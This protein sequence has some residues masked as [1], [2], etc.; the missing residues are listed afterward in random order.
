MIVI[1]QHY[2][3]ESKSL[4]AETKIERAGRTCYKTED[5][6]STNSANKFVRML[7]DKG[8]HAMIEFAD[9]T[10]VFITNR[11][12]THELVRHRLCSFAQESTRY[13]RYD[14]RMEIIRPMWCRDTVPLGEY[15]GGSH[16]YDH[17]RDA[18]QIPCGYDTPE[19]RWIDS[20]CRAEQDYKILINLGWTPQQAREVL[21]NSL[22]TE[23][24]VKANVREWRHIFTLRCSKYAHPQMYDLMRPLLADCIEQHPAIFEDITF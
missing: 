8:H 24:V 7:R 14:G 11:G 12:V 19:R 20:C 10:T 22:K 16:Y 1:D 3:I 13:V 15:P 17:N 21:P 4:F 9:M 6:I 5:K 23:I 18:I 2:I